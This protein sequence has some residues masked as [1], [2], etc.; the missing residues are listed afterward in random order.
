MVQIFAQS[1]GIEQTDVA[2]YIV[3]GNQRLFFHELQR[4]FIMSFN[5]A[6]DRMR[7]SG[8]DRMDAWDVPLTQYL[9]SSPSVEVFLGSMIDES[10][11]RYKSWHGTN[12]V[13]DRIAEPIRRLVHFKKKIVPR[14]N[15]TLVTKE[16][17][18]ESI[19]PGI[20]PLISLWRLEDQSRKIIGGLNNPTDQDDL[21][22]PAEMSD[23]EDVS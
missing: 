21:T 20:R 2:E 6:F 15:H 11:N 12:M 17:F 16:E 3:E 4:T 13:A 9:K 1:I 7:P 8:W 10:Y 14:E 22:S 23:V 18:V 5:E 19:R